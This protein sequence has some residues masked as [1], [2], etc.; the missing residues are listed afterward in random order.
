M[1]KSD[2]AFSMIGVFALVFLIGGMFFSIADNVFAFSEQESY[3][4]ESYNL[5]ESEM[6]TFTEESVML[7]PPYSL[8][9]TPVKENQKELEKKLE[10]QVKKDGKLQAVQFSNLEFQIGQVEK[11]TLRMDATEDV[12]RATATI[13]IPSEDAIYE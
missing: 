1:M 3:V 11:M 9:K 8:I 4:I 13:I 2:N 6:V 5:S 10:V 12:S 7:L